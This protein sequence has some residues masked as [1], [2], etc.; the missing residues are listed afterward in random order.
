METKIVKPSDNDCLHYPGYKLEHSFMRYAGVAVFLINDLSF[1][2]L[3]NFED[4]DLF[5]I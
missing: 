4:P 5:I 2:S 1:R 3:A